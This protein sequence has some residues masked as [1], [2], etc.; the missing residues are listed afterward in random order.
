MTVDCTIKGNIGFMILNRPQALHALSLPM[1][2][3]MT[4]H[5]LAWHSD[6][7]IHAVIIQAAPSKAF[8]AGGDIRQIYDLRGEFSQQLN[9]FER[10]YRLNQLIHDFPKPYIAL[11]D[12]ITMGGG[13]GI[14]L[15]GSH[16]IASEHFVFS[17][18]ETGI[19]FFPDIGASHILAKCPGQ[20]GYYL[21]LTGDRINAD[22]ACELGLIKEV[23]P[24]QS[25]PKVVEALLKMDLSQNAYQKVDE[26]LASYAVKTLNSSLLQKET[27]IKECFVADGIERILDRLSRHNDPWF[28]EVHDRLLTKAPLSLKVTL[29]QL[30]S[31]KTKNLATCLEMD[32]RLVRH[33]LQDHDFYEGIRA[34]VVDK[35]QHP[36]W[37]PADLADVTPMMVNRYFECI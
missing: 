8:C 29:Q 34:V 37:Q 23:V 3:T 19:G 35:D 17:L 5:L 9:F 13:V 10:E 11:M 12:G 21:G 20:F 7:N 22:D 33:F 26:C 14:A 4:K 36:Y 32:G 28:Q 6:V 16:P 2:D 31:T 15:H 30:R 24:A 1:I 27:G 25:F 18:P